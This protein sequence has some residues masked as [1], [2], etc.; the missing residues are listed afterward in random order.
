V[1]SPALTF[2]YGSKTVACRLIR[3]E[4]R[5][6]QISVNPDMSVEVVAPKAATEAAIRKRLNR[7][8]PWILRQIEFFRQFHPRTPERRY[9]PGETHLYLGRRYRLK[10]VRSQEPCVKLISGRIVVAISNPHDRGSVRRMVEDWQQSQA[11][12]WFEQR[13][14]LCIRRFKNGQ[15]V[16]PKSLIVRHLTQ[17][18][19]SMSPSGR[20]VLNRLLVQA[21]PHEIDY[22][23]THELCHRI[24]HHHGPKFFDLL[25]R[26]MPDWPARKASLERRLA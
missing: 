6:L 8:A 11:R 20:L 5:T 2:A 21:A 4:R 19:G 17:R 13:I 24:H 1:T 7:R 18:W 9:E 16:A 26:M 14:G 23:I 3:R 15:A 10:I 25:D 12:R 22:V